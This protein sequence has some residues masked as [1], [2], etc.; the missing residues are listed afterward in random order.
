VADIIQSNIGVTP[1]ASAHALLNAS[2]VGRVILYL[3]TAGGRPIPPAGVPHITVQLVNAAGNVV[4]QTLTNRRGTYA[5]NR[6][7][8]GSYALQLAGLPPFLSL[9]SAPAAAQVSRGQRLRGYN[10]RLALHLDVSSA[11]TAA[12]LSQLGIASRVGA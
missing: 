10:F 5:F 7:Q 11:A 9:A 6:V 4:D 3:G 12:A 2:I 8:A 1:L